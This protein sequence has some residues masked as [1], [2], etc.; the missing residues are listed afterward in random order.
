[1]FLIMIND[2]INHTI[3]TDEWLCNNNNNKAF[4]HTI[5]KVVRTHVCYYKKGISLLHCS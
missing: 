4:M 1:M 5:I 3:T 2:E